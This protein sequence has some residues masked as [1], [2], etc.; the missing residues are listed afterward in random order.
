MVASCWIF[1]D[2]ELRCSH[3]HKILDKTPADPVA[4][5]IPSAG[6]P[7]TYRK[8]KHVVGSFRLDFILLTKGNT[9]ILDPCYEI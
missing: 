2:T 5:R 6:G 4:S 8:S 9:C 7:Q 3:E 1:I